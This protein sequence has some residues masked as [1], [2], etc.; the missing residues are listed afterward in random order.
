MSKSYI[1]SAPWR[2]HGVA[3]QLYFI[4]LYFTA[5]NVPPLGIAPL[6]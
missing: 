6:A 1:S 3:G 2:L 5:D 4:L